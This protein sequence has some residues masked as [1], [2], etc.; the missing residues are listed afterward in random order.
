MYLTL[1]SLSLH[2][3]TYITKSFSSLSIFFW[4]F[5]FNPYIFR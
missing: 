2:A 4:Y 3:S 5:Y 1:L